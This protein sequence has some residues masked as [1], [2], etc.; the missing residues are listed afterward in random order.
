MKNKILRYSMQMAMIV[1]LL[2]SELITEKEFIALRMK[3]MLDYHI[4]S[5]LPF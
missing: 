3:L 4:P 5:D 1:Q 2:H